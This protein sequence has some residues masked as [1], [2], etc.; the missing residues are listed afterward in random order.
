MMDDGRKVASLSMEELAS[1]FGFLTKDANG[2]PV[3]LPH[4]AENA[5][6]EDPAHPS[7]AE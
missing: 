1:L 4:E 2:N 3:L 6:V 5:P 7:Q